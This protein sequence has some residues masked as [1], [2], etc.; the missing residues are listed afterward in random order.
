MIPA[1]CTL[2]LVYNT[3]FVLA[4]AKSNGLGKQNEVKL[5]AIEEE[6]PPNTFIGNI[7]QFSSPQ[8][9]YQ[10]KIGT[11]RLLRSSKI[12]HYFRLDEHTGDVYSAVRIDR[13]ALCEESDTCCPQAQQPNAPGVIVE[14]DDDFTCVLAIHVQNDVWNFSKLLTVFIEIIDV[15]DNIPHFAQTQLFLSISESKERGSAIQLPLA[16][17]L[18]T[19]R[20]GIRNYR[21]DTRS[22]TFGLRIYRSGSQITRLSLIILRDLD[23]ERIPSFAIKVTAIDGGNRFGSLTVNIT[24]T[25]ENDCAPLFWE[26]TYTAEVY[27][28]QPLHRTI[29]QVHATDDDTGENARIEYSLGRTSAVTSKT[30]SIDRHSGE[31]FLIAPLSSVTAKYFELPVIAQDCGKKMQLSSFARVF[32]RILTSTNSTLQILLDGNRGN[33]RLRIPENEPAGYRVADVRL[34]GDERAEGGG[35]DHV[36]CRQE[37]FRDVFDLVPENQTN[38]FSLVSL[39]SVDREECRQFAIDI[40]CMDFLA[41]SQGVMMRL[42]VEV[43]DKNDNR[44]KFLQH[45]VFDIPENAE[46][47]TI[48]GK[49]TATD[50]DTGDNAILTYYLPNADKSPFYIDPHSGYLYTKHAVDREICSTIYQ[51]VIAYDAGNSRSLSGITNVTI[52]VTDKNDNAPVFGASTPETLHINASASPHQV[53]YQLNI[54]DADL[55]N[56]GEVRVSLL[57]YSDV[58]GVEETGGLYLRTSIRERKTLRYL[59][60]IVARDRGIPPLETRKNLTIKIIA[61]N[62]H[63]PKFASREQVINISDCTKPGRIIHAVT[64]VDED[65]GV[66]GLISYHFIGTE[67]LAA[68]PFTID[69]VTGEIK[70]SSVPLKMGLHKVGV[71]AADFGTP[72]LSDVLLLSINVVKKKLNGA[73]SIVSKSS[74]YNT[75]T[76]ATVSLFSSF[77]FLIIVFFIVYKA[78]FVREDEQSRASIEMPYTSTV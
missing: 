17:D 49:V 52:H 1:T 69:S 23:R 19:S 15:N 5:P 78:F 22:T 35:G 26:K 66:S 68:F 28:W 56:N 43:I 10:K 53:L 55:G 73:S 65:V 60:Q 31:L 45:F 72:T 42:H 25:D 62:K 32:V 4:S 61:D 70:L 29:L 75:L 21:L 67:N 48:V 20:Y 6:M 41:P 59:L 27:R 57:R 34:V 36:K 18:D 54:S 50:A 38:A 44:P 58:F 3:F 46:Q 39:R 30:F 63:R 24:L 14:P 77:S 9:F 12:A 64:A 33:K 47:G 37:T 13:E 40:S 7:P 11:F 51:S 2:W 74:A 16:M 76:V 8:L 71:V